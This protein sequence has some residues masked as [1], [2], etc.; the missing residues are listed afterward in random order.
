[1]FISQTGTLKTDEY[2]DI[3]HQLMDIFSGQYLFERN[4]DNP[5]IVMNGEANFKHESDSQISY[6][7][8][9]FYFLNN[10][11]YEFYQKRY[12]CFKG[13]F[14]YIFTMNKKI[15]HK[16]MLSEIEKPHYAFQH[17]HKCNKDKYLLDFFLEKDE[18]IMRYKVRGSSKN[19]NIETRF[20]K[21]Y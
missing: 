18:M 8:S 16:I 9:G 20:K 5:K 6:N 11:E 13:L 17:S 7:E 10:K 3:K 15:L 12:F 21:N 14:L 2:I 1:M 19:Y 4:I